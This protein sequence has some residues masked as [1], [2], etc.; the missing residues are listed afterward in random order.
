M[1]YEKIIGLP[2]HTSRVRGRMPR[3]N[4]AAQ[5]APYAALV[6]FDL[7]IAEEGRITEE[8]TV[9]SEYEIERLDRLLREAN[10]EEKPVRITYFSKDKLKSGGSYFN[11]SGRIVSLDPM[12]GTL[13]LDCGV[14]INLSEIIDVEENGNEP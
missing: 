13:K 10:E 9:L 1:R 6:G 7:E 11:A 12:N 2:H 3:E 4:R 14:I 5:F 8:K